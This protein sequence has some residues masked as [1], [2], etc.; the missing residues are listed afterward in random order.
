M[1]SKRIDIG[2][3]GTVWRSLRGER[4]GNATLM[5]ALGVPALIGGAGLGVDMA[6]WYLWKSEL[7]YAVD[8]AAIAAAYARADDSTKNDYSTRALQEFAANTGVIRHIAATPSVTLGDFAGGTDNLITVASSA[9]DRLPFSSFITGSAVSVSSSASATFEGNGTAWTSCLI[10]LHP[11]ASKAVWF[12]GGPD[13][14]AG[15]GVA[16]LSNAT[17]AIEVS[18]GSGTLDLGWVIA[19][20]GI[21]NYFDSISGTTVIEN[22]VGLSNPF[23]GLTPPGNPVSRTLSCGSNGG[24]ETTYAATYD[25]TAHTYHLRYEGPKK[26]QMSLVSTTLVDTNVYTETGGATA[27]TQVG[28]TSTTTG[29]PQTVSDGSSGSGKDKLYWQV[30]S[31]VESTATVTSVQSSGGGTVSA[32]MMQPGTYSDFDLSCD[33]VLAPGIYVI[34]GGDIDVNA[35]YSLSGTGV[36]FVL[37]NGAGIK[38][39]GGASI[40]LTAMDKNELIAEGVSS[41]DAD[42]LEGML[43]FEDPSSSGNSKNKINGNS[44]TYLN[45]SI[46]LPVSGVEILGTAGVTSRCLTIAANTI[47][48]GGTADL[49]T[50]CPPGM[51]NDTEV[52]A[53]DIRVRLVS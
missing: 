6:Q 39:N 35:Q 44:S 33:T 42:K 23:A 15:C 45:G 32:G 43:V 2:R 24:G 50:F 25:V 19:A 53:G 8:Q 12:N 34:D 26:N 16:A 48:I 17:N 30:D 5:V 7:Q 9:S 31:V 37:K 41:A 14:D 52:M 11:S 4:S 27:S 28:D 46:Y 51:V 36:M 3:M 13:V 38:I 20:G 40:S 29:D 21:D 18:G 10:A 1:G 22:A 49:S 47:K